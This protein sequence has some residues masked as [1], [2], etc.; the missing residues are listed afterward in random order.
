MTKK[1]TNS[2]RLINR[3]EK[4]SPVIKMEH[5]SESLN[6]ILLELTIISEEYLIDDLE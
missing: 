3:Q 5:N 6:Q 2:I 1:M 4:R